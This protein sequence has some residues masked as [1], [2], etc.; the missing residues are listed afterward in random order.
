MQQRG[1]IV[2]ILLADPR[3]DPSAQD[4]RAMVKALSAINLNVKILKLLLF[5]HR[6]KHSKQ[7]NQSLIY[8]L[9]S[10]FNRAVRYS[11]KEFHD[12]KLILDDERLDPPFRRILFCMKI[13]E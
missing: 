12:F 8:S 4:Y 2:E 10:A 9:Q 3:V 7:N 13:L 5:D 6:V 1:E 11:I